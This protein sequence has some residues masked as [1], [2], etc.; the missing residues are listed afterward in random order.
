M[1][2]FFLGFLAL[3][4]V[5]TMQAQN[6]N[7]KTA[8]TN[9]STSLS[10]YDT[11]PT[12]SAELEKARKDIDYAAGHEKTMT[13]PRVWRTRGKI[14]NRVAFNNELKSKNKDA[15][16]K[17]LE[18][19]DKAWDLEAAKLKEKGKDI[20]K[21]PAKPEFQSGYE[22][23]ARALYN[24]GADAYN[25]ENYE[26][27]YQSFMGIMGITP[28]VKE[29]LA[30]KPVKLVTITKI[31]MVQEAARLGG[32]AAIQL[33]KPEEAE[34]LLLPLLDGKKID[35]Q[36]IP[37]TYSMLATSWQKAGNMNKAK[38]I[39]GKARQL[40]PANQSL[41]I[42]E[43]N[44]ALSEGKLK[45]LEGKLKQAVEADKENVELHFVLG[46]VYDGIFR[47]KLE[48]GESEVASDFF[49]KAVDWYS[50]AAEI[51]TKH[52]NSLYSL[53]ALHVN[54]SNSF[55]KDMNEITNMKDPK[56]KEL[57][58]GYNN[59]LDKGLV[60]L[61]AAEK[62]QGDDIGVAIAL[63]EVYSRKNDENNYMKY[64][65]KVERLQK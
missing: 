53:G 34:R 46:N 17:A 20:G 41:L 58:N 8:T 22:A 52:F 7:P 39:L 36:F 38:E 47:E 11:D 40:Y 62:I 12:N 26:L 3:A 59:L 21:I 4:S 51:D 44:I 10:L 28:R 37:T 33:G 64:K 56:Y 61:L 55:A 14:Y 48:A 25:A 1:K 63:K 29:G 23:T 31:D 13:D 19:F 60:H 16:V 54:Y 5:A 45:E 57:E 15:G 65:A 43:I 18:S 6:Q 2:K 49:K 42:S 27:A 30:K 35:E 24:G 9:A 32:M 50:K